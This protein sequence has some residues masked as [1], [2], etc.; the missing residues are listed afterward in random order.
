MELDAGKA[1]NLSSFLDSG[2]F[3]LDEGSGVFFLDP[4][5]I[6][7]KSYSRYIPQRSAY[8]SRSLFP[9]EKGSED[10]IDSETRNG[11]TPGSSNKKRKTKKKKTN[12]KNLNEREMAA[13]LR[14]QV[15]LGCIRFIRLS[16]AVC[17]DFL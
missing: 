2:I 14:H 11:D 7:A 10:R 17:S 4:V 3:P 8:Y 12:V 5:R 1:G 15:T 13:E 16:T 9:P 6:L